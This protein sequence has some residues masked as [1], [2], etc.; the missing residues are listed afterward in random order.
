M[1]RLLVIT[2]SIVLAGC[3][4]IINHNEF[5]SSPDGTPSPD[6]SPDA[7]LVPS[8]VTSSSTT[9]VV[10]AAA[11]FDFTGNTADT[12]LTGTKLPNGT[13]P[14]TMTRPF[15]LSFPGIFDDSDAPSCVCS[16]Y[17]GGFHACQ[18]SAQTTSTLTIDIWSNFGSIDTD[19]EGLGVM[20][21]GK[22]PS[23]VGSIAIAPPSTSYRLASARVAANGDVSGE[24]GDWVGTTDTTSAAIG[25]LR[26]PL[27]ELSAP[28]CICTWTGGPFDVC[29]FDDPPS[30]QLAVATTHGPGDFVAADFACVDDDQHTDR[31]VTTPRSDGMKLTSA[32]I[33]IDG[34]RT[35]E[36]GVWIADVD[37]TVDHTVTF[38]NR[39]FTEAPRCICSSLTD[40]SLSCIAT[41][42]PD[43]ASVKIDSHRFDGGSTA[44]DV[45]LICMGRP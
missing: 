13:G 43:S 2:T 45:S 21:V 35:R 41:I 24:D 40:Q 37:G 14:G 31:R 10:V 26:L 18:I 29:K 7:P 12:W 44:S 42:G 34:D 3:Q 4:L 23:D 8:T 25:L 32:T 9:G 33:R 20:C 27:T 38:A 30:T 17:G 16:T 36:D 11:Q 39:V 22:A 5:S 1:K 15:Q 28:R 19:V 6:A